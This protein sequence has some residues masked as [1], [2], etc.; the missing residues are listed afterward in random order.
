MYEVE[1]QATAARPGA[2][3]VLSPDIRGKMQELRKALER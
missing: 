2:R 3:P 1:K